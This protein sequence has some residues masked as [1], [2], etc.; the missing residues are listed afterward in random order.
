MKKIY[1]LL[2][3]CML[4]ASSWGQRMPGRQSGQMPEGAV[5]VYGH[6]LDTFLIPAPMAVLTDTASFVPAVA[7]RSG[8]KDRAGHLWFGTWEGIYRYDGKKFTVYKEEEVAPPFNRTYAILSRVYCMLEDRSGKLWFGTPD[9]VCCYNGNAFIHY[10]LPVALNVR[11]YYPTG[12]SW[13]HNQLSSTCVVGM[14]E[15]RQG[16]L[17][18]GTWGGGAYCYDGSAFT[19]ISEKDG[20]CQNVVQCFYEDKAGNFWFGTRGKGMCFYDGKTFLPV[21][22]KD[23]SDDH[24]FHILEDKRGD[25]WFS[26]R[27]DGVFRYNGKEYTNYFG[28]IAVAGITEDNKG[29]LWFGSDGYGAYRFDGKD[30]SNLTVKEGLIN[31]SVWFILEDQQK[32]L[33]FGT[34]EGLCRYDGTSF[35]NFTNI[36]SKNE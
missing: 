9:G 7:V 6:G 14:Y 8:V 2:V 3:S 11:D 4:A 10:P 22:M 16:K 21:H 13:H 17:W 36:S 19:N 5:N 29:V 30:I 25:V 26:T 28:D 24:F 12:I 32:R 1:P 18:F 20:L 27:R 31:N 33:W 15:D 23:E 34:R 35:T